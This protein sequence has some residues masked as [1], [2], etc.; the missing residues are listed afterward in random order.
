MNGLTLFTMS[1]KKMM[2]ILPPGLI[3]GLIWGLGLILCLGLLALALYF[4][5]HK[6]QILSLKG[7]YQD[8][9]WEKEAWAAPPYHFEVRNGD[10]HGWIESSLKTHEG[11]LILLN[12]WASWCAPCIEE[13]PA[14]DRLQAGFSKD[15]FVILPV[16]LDIATDQEKAISLWKQL[17]LKQMAM[18]RDRL[19]KEKHY[20]AIANF[21]LLTFPMSFLLDRDGMVVARL[22]GSA[23]WDSD[24]AMRLIDGLL[25]GK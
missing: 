3:W 17:G 2:L 5:I 7:D 9:S 16:S 21:P 12:F 10:G 8:L 6:P 19:K 22:L 15:D 11:K 4:Y 20:K 1:N 14:L 13:L 18:A 25:E 24:E 23:K